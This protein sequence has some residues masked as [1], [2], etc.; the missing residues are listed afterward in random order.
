MPLEDITLALF[1]ACNSIRIVAYLPQLHKAAIDRNGASAVSCATWMLFLVAH[2][3]TVAY[4]IVN[5]SDWGL[6]ALFST[7]ALCCAAI[8]AIT[9][10]KRRRLVRP[11]LP[12]AA[13]PA[14][15]ATAC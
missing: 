8:L 7:N 14:L 2:L 5:R 3:S 13:P 9:Y 6:A 10:W 1:A 4:A 11:A 15:R 12:H